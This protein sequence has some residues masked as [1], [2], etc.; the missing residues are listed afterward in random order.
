MQ[1]MEDSE[2]KGGL[3]ADEMGLGKTVQRYGGFIPKLIEQHRTT[4]LKTFCRPQL[5]D[6]IN[7][8]PC[9]PS[10]AMVQ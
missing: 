9:C 3:L 7:L 10:T 1:K 4:R 2:H 6:N 5:Q 8:Y